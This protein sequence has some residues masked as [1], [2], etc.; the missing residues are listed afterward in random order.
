MSRILPDDTRGDQ[1][2][3]TSVLPPYQSSSQRTGHTKPSLVSNS[4]TKSGT[5]RPQSQS[6]LGNQTDHP[7]SIP[8]S[9]HRAA[10]TIPV[11]N[12]IED[13]Q[14]Y[15]PYIRQRT[16]SSPAPLQ[17]EPSQLSA[18]VG[19][20]FEA[21]SGASGLEPRSPLHKRPPASRSCHGIE[22][23]SGPP[24]ALSTHRSYQGDSAWRYTQPVDLTGLG[25]Q[26]K[27]ISSIDALVRAKQPVTD[28]Y[29]DPDPNKNIP[30]I[31]RLL[32]Q[33]MPAMN[34]T[35]LDHNVHHKDEDQGEATLRGADFP[36]LA[37]AS[38]QQARPERSELQAS[39]EDL[40]LNLAHADSPG[41]GGDENLRE[42]QR[43][44]VRQYFIEPR[45]FSF[46][47]DMDIT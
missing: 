5:R 14:T 23:L 8:P 35:A 26:G 7:P 22:T 43:R 6:S 46:D 44:R 12:D 25:R 32:K 21:Q 30:S 27:A 42:K 17:A 19:S 4:Q 31:E 38:A 11:K 40:F 10:A 45:S 20:Y 24:P 36:Q 29:I 3:T 15:T 1:T 47:G 41:E 33:P 16:I 34:R 9:H 2:S 13:S 28:D 37:F 39:Q 18:P